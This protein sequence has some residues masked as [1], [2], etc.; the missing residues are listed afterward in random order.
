MEMMSHLS[1][2]CSKTFHLVGHVVVAGTDE[3][4]EA[5]LRGGR[6]RALD[7]AEVGRDG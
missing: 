1:R 2:N 7:F 5:V 3:E 6:L 4:F